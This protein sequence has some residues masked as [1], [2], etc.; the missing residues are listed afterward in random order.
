MTALG[1]LLGIFLVLRSQL[2]QIRTLGDYA[3]PQSTMVYS[4][5]GQLIGMLQTERRTVV[6][7]SAL[8]RH[9]VLAFFG[10]RRRQLLRARRHRL[11]RY[12]ARGRQETCAQARTCRVPAPS[13]NKR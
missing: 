8:P 9:V 10:R 6:P 1:S 7:F 2:P 5:D 4:D 12:L 11:L 3:P 13:R